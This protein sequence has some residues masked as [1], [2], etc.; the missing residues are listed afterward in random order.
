MFNEMLAGGEIL[1]AKKLFEAAIERCFRL[2]SFPCKDLIDR[3]SKDDGLEEAF[4]ILNKMVCNGY[5]FDPASFMPVI[6]ALTKRGRK[7]EADELVERMLNMAAVDK[8]YIN[9][10]YK[11]LPHGISS[12][13]L[14]S[15]W[16]TILQRYGFSLVVFS[17]IVCAKSWSIFS[18]CCLH[19]PKNKF[20]ICI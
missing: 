18:P 5:G 9:G 3:L 1:E 19:Y 2:D 10:V 12:R 8:V 7:H 15:E 14:A 4:D 20:G 17:S 6:D 16:K 13:Y 11:Q